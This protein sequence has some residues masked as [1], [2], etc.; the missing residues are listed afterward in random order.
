MPS[1][2]SIPQAVYIMTQGRSRDIWQR[3]DIVD[4]HVERW[5]TLTFES[6]R[7]LEIYEL[8][9][10]WSWRTSGYEQVSAKPW[11][12]GRICYHVLLSFQ[13]F[14]SLMK[15]GSLLQSILW[16]RHRCSGP[17]GISPSSTTHHNVHQ[18]DESGRHTTHQHATYQKILSQDQ[19]STSPDTKPRN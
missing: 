11:T 16:I 2:I 17:R 8:H 1:G 10:A 19:Q 5:Q 7:G 9:R 4:A 6:E 3:R 18:T 12:L 15:P 14:C 13:L